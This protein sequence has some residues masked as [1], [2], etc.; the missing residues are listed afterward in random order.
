MA[1]GEI[2]VSESRPE[3]DSASE[4]RA[5]GC[6]GDRQRF[7]YHW[8]RFRKLQPGANLGQRGAGRGLADP[9]QLGAVFEIIIAI[10]GDVWFD[11]DI[12]ALLRLRADDLLGNRKTLAD[13][14]EDMPGA[15]AVGP[16]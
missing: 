3:L 1:C 4:T 13:D 12:G 10:A 2:P 15:H 14:I 9:H 11:D 6:R 16:I 8:F 7:Q 5:S